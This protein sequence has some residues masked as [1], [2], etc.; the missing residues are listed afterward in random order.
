MKFHVSLGLLLRHR[1]NLFTLL[2]YH[3]VNVV[4]YLMVDVI[5]R[6]SWV[7]SYYCFVTIIDESS[8]IYFCLFLLPRIRFFEQFIDHLNRLVFLSDIFRFWNVSSFTW[9]L[10]MHERCQNPLFL[11]K[12]IFFLLLHLKFF[13]NIGQGLKNHLVLNNLFIQWLNAEELS[14]T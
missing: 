1:C 9:L 7:I 11:Y 2:P 4:F 6:I 8:C 13:V 10:I 3:G 14:F 12:C 5:S